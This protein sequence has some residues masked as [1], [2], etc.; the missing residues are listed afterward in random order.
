MSLDKLTVHFT[1]QAKNFQREGYSVRSFERALVLP[2][3]VVRAVLRGGFKEQRDFHHI[4]WASETLLISSVR[5]TLSDWLLEKGKNY[6]VL[7]DNFNRA[8]RIAA[9]VDVGRNSLGAHITYLS[10]RFYD[11]SSRKPFFVLETNFSLDGEVG[12][13]KSQSF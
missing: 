5:A 1:S 10:L 11:K 3:E 6:R 12:E 9:L 2:G 8:S 13:I 7:A 4:F